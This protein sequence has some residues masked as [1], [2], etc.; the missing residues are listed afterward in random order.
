MGNV[1]VLVS[2]PSEFSLFKIYLQLLYSLSFNL[3]LRLEKKSST[4]WKEVHQS[5]E[6]R[7]YLLRFI[8]LRSRASDFISLSH[9]FC[10]AVVV[11]TLEGCFWTSR[12]MTPEKCSVESSFSALNSY[13]YPQNIAALIPFLT[14][15]SFH[16]YFSYVITECSPFSILTSLK[17]VDFS[18]PPWSKLPRSDLL[19]MDEWMRWINERMV[20][21]SVCPSL[22]MLPAIGN[23]H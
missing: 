23:T 4:R 13:Y 1:L 15:C 16:S 8:V 12:E 14:I 17:S 5:S 2:F 9:G 3:Q 18:S 6:R 21:L 20:I 19:R 22:V 10:L 11:P 7:H